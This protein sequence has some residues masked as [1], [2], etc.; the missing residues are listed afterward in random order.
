MRYPQ[1]VETDSNI[2]IGDQTA[3]RVLLRSDFGNRIEEARVHFNPML[4]CAHTSNELGRFNVDNPLYGGVPVSL[5]VPDESAKRRNSS[6]VCRNVKGSYPPGSFFQLR[7]GLYMAS[8]EL[9]YI[10]MA[11]F[12]SEY[13]LAEIGLNLCAKYFIEN[14]TNDIL[15]RSTYLTTPERLRAYVDQASHMRGSKRAENALRWVIPNSGSPAESKMKL[16][17]CNPLVH[18]GMG[19]PFDAMNYDVKAGC[20]SRFT[21][22]DDYSIDLVDTNT[23]VCLEY[24]GEDYHTDQSRDAKRINELA[25]LGWNVFVID[26]SVLYNPDATIRAGEQLARL[27]HV[28]IRRGAGWERKFIKLRNAL[29][30]PV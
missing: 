10:R 9:V 6:I 28:R 8:P 16:Q 22:Q 5:L 23:R 27:M 26:K 15:Q 12:V 20:L 19:L 4:S 18:G 29:D 14:D 11:Q 25:V 24:N 30:L 1:V 13:R 17:F 21:L 3:L 2:I 7:S